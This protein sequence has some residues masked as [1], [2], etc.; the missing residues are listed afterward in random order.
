MLAPILSLTN[1]RVPFGLFAQA[2]VARGDYAHR[3]SEI[4]QFWKDWQLGK[5]QPELLRE[6][7]IRYIVVRKTSEG[8]PTMVPPVISKV[9]ENS[10]FAIFKVDPQRLGETLPQTP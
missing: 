2:A 6:A 3:E 10:E 8:F 9:F 4:K 7:Q 1:C 5:L